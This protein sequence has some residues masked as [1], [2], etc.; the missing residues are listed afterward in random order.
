MFNIDF[1]LVQ[2]YIL[3]SPFRDPI[4][5][6]P[7]LPIALE[8][9]HFIAP[10]FLVFG[11]APLYTGS[12]LAPV[13]GVHFTAHQGN[14]LCF[15]EPELGFN[16]FERRAIFP[17]HFNDAV[18]FSLTQVLEWIHLLVVCNYTARSHFGQKRSLF[19]HP[20]PIF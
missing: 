13:A 5:T 11:F 20:A 1:L 3:T 16:G 10:Q 6:D 17:S 14:D 9:S 7:S 15:T 4:H 2:D 8:A 19:R 12:P 18:D